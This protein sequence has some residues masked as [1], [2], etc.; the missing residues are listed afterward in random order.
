MTPHETIAGGTTDSPWVLHFEAQDGA[1]DWGHAEDFS[2]LQALYQAAGSPYR[3]T[4]YSSSPQAS[5]DAPAFDL[6][7]SV[8]ERNVGMQRLGCF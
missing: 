3:I 5:D 7:M 4:R 1:E 2:N 8:Q 6:P